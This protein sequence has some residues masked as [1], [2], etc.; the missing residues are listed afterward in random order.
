MFEDC[1]SLTTVPDLNA[2]LL[3]EFCYANMFKGCTSLV[4]PPAIKALRYASEGAI[5]SGDNAFM[6]M[7]EDCTSLTKLPKLYFTSVRTAGVCGHMFTG[8]TKIK[9]STTQTGEYQNAYPLL[10]ITGYETFKN[11][12]GTYTGNGSANTTYYT[13]NEIIE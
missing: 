3:N 9:M 11:T 13:S 12:G 8:C 4:T 2:E 10:N 1:T 7:F 5:S 6:H